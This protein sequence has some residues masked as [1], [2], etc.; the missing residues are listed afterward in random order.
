MFLILIVDTV[1]KI[2]SS[3]SIYNLD[4][5]LGSPRDLFLA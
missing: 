1:P 4:V 3:F 2:F 5:P